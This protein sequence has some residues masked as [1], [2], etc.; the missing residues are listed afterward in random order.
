MNEESNEYQFPSPVPLFLSYK[1]LCESDNVGQDRFQ[2]ISHPFSYKLQSE[3][4]TEDSGKYQFLDLDPTAP[5][6]SFPATQ[7]R[8]PLLQ[9]SP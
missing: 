4:K 6:V 9:H 1:L 2:I 8:P 5:P 3:C 7:S